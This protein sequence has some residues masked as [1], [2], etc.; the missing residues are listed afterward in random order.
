MACVTETWYVNGETSVVHVEGYSVA[1]GY[2]RRT[3][4][5]GGVLILVTDGLDFDV[6]DLNRFCMGMVFECVGVAVKT[7]LEAVLVFWNLSW[8]Y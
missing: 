4:T 5:H 3:M 8:Q 7:H 1:A 2:E 6:C